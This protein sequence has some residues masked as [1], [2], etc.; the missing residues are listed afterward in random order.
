MLAGSTGIGVA[1]V[2]TPAPVAAIAP[3]DGAV[4][5]VAHPVE[6]TFAAPVAN[7]LAAER[8]LLAWI[9]T[10]VTLMGFGFVVARFGLVLE[11][12][13]PGSSRASA[14]HAAISTAIGIILV[15]VGAV[16]MGAAAWEHR[17]YVRRLDRQESHVPQSWLSAVAAALLAALG[18]GVAAYL[19]LSSA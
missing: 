12:V 1:A 3:A 7:R 2:N 8:T 5:G 6:V 15:L 13:K 11:A 10:G 16:M 9:R 14:P 4:V 18:L 19:F 17:Q